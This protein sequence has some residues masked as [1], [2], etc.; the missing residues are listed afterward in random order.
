MSADRE[1][2]MGMDRVQ[3]GDWFYN[4]FLNPVEVIAGHLEG[5]LTGK[6]DDS[7]VHPWSLDQLKELQHVHAMIVEANED[8]R[9]YWEKY[10]VGDA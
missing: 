2:T 5:I 9:E 4:E 8:L 7:W 6:F 10:Y 3:A 1:I